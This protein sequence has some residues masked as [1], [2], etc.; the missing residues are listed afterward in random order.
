MATQKDES[1]SVEFEGWKMKGKGL[2]GDFKRWR[3]LILMYWEIHWASN[4][5]NHGLRNLDKCSKSDA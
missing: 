3:E 1:N 4:T 5:E 2:V